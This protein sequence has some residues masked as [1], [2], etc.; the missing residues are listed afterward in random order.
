MP[1]N[2]YL[3]NSNINIINQNNNNAITGGGSNIQGNTNA[4]VFKASLQDIPHQKSQFGKAKEQSMIANV[5][6]SQNRNQL[7]AGTAGNV[8]LDSCYSRA[9]AIGAGA[10]NNNRALASSNE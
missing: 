4:N 1:T 7:V 6:K 10:P 2:N 8:A 9:S 3:V 5:A